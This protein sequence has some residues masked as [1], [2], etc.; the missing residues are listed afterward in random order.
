MKR[1]M[2]AAAAALLLLSAGSATAARAATAAAPPPGV[3]VSGGMSYQAGTH[4]PATHL[5]RFAPFNTALKA[6][7]WSGY[8]DVACRTC[9]IRYVATSFTVPSVNCPKS[10][11]GSFAGIFAGLD[12][13]TS[14]TVEQVG[15]EAGCSGGTASYAAFYEMFPNPPVSF[16]GISPGDAISLSVYFNSATHHWQLA[17]TDVT[18]GGTI[19]TAQA[20]PSGSA[21]RNSSAE[22]IAEA[23]SSSPSTILP[24]V[25]FGQLNHVAIAVTSLN[26]TRGA[27]TSNGLWTTDSITMVSS[28]G[29]T[30]AQP[31]PVYGG[32]AF[33][34][35]WKAAS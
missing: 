16:S 11:D 35:T 4:L 12:G 24:L 14:Q 32:Q 31:G 29:K 13:I 7:N 23:P 28:A 22:V 8:A 25:D 15:V 26:G 10:P 1:I 9:A 21:C 17:L 33:Q 19:A 5:P 6:N 18:T 3:H 30:L 27:M 2:L 20:C 34:D